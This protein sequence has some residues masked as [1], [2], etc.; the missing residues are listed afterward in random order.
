MDYLD[1]FGDWLRQRR[2]ALRLTRP[3]L[4]KC[5][6]CSVSAL[7]K[8]E[9]DERRPSR[10]LAGMLAGCLQIPPEEQ[11]LFLEV[12]RGLQRVARLGS[13]VSASGPLSP[14]IAISE[15]PAGPDWHLPLP[16]TGLVG[17]EAELSSL[18]GLLSDPGCRLLTLVGPG[19]IGKSRLGIEAACNVWSR[20]ADGVFFAPLAATGSPEFMVPAIAEAVGANFSGPT[21]PRRQLLNHLGNKQMLL[22]LDNLEHLLD[23]VDLLVEIL[24]RAP[25]VKLL[26]TSR[27]RLKLQAEWVFEVQ[28]LPVPAEGETEGLEKVSS[29]QLFLRRAG[30]AQVDF[31]PSI[32]ERLEVVRICRLVEG[33]PLAIEL[34]AAWV[35][36]LSC[37]EIAEEIE[38]GLD[39]LT[40]QLRDVPER[41]RS[42][43]AVFDYSWKLL[44]GEEQH[45]LRR[46]SVFRGDFQ[47][48]AAEEV[49]GAGLPLLSALATKSFLR[50]TA[51]GRYGLHEL[52]RQYAASKLAEDPQELHTTQERHSSYYLAL[53]GEKDAKLRS[54]LQR[55]AVSELTGEIDNIRAAWDWSTGEQQFIP[56]YR[57][58]TTLMYLL[59]VRN[60][61]K[62]GELT[63][64]RAADALRATLSGG[65]ASAL[66][67]AALQAMM[68]HYGFFLLR[69]GRGADA[70]AVLSPSA[71][72][73]RTAGEPLATI[74]SL[75]YL[76]ISCLGLGKFS[77]A[78]ECLQN[79][80]RLAQQHQQRWYEACATEFLGALALDQGQYNQARPHLS[81]ALALFHQLGDPGM[82]ASTLRYLGMTMK[83]LGEYRQA[84]KLLQESLR[85]AREIGYSWVIGMA[86]NGLGQVAYD[87]GKHEEASAYLLEST[88]LFQEMGDTDSL[89]V[90]LNNQGLN[91]LALNQARDARRN[92]VSALRTAYEGG[93]IP[94]TLTALA[95]LA[96]LETSQEASKDTLE[97][98]IYIRQHPSKFQGTMD[99]AVRLQSELES[100]LAE[101]EIEAA[102]ERARSMDLE[103]MVRQILADA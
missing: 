77:E 64:R 11:P 102:R 97:L 22:L 29:I 12:A 20:F 8:I 103:E 69:Q 89:V 68:A 73:L 60:W 94:S 39:I 55:E 14:G 57:V 1:S 52:I 96:A 30:Q 32:E 3:Q 45:V 82:T 40:T 24:E 91:A 49:S 79:C 23:G 90:V 33:M 71:A 93:F 31:E 42:L 15:P 78:E 2:E 28:G 63:F 21:A 87:Q 10:P 51:T 6:S 92:F 61:F 16:M 44:T 50:H 5:A 99:L 88:S 81:E 67:Q 38:R 47:R 86:L 41:Q 101:E 66:H 65:E 46:L 54:H 62:E 56:L 36:V 95:G 7:R 25:G 75:L 18:E 76:G 9:A 19:G 26:A 70:Y 58:S 74:C 80:L 84:E 43:Q 48:Q 4:A 27:E 37:M 17:R 34:A 13:P 72:F 98:V 53:L 83:S 35:P 85:L 59:E 100:R